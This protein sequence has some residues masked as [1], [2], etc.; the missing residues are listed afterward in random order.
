MNIAL[1]RDVEDFLQSQVRAG[2]CDTPGKLINDLVR[3]VRDQQ[4]KPFNVTPELEK[5]L[6][7]AADKPT[8]PLTPDD[9]AG[10]R[11]RAQS[12]KPSAS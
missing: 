2:V 9:F 3:S 7:E 1:D 10:I 11:E 8:T 12:R 6:L 5:W 4:Q